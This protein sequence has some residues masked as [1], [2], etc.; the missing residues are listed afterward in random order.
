MS[1]EQ[2]AELLEQ[3]AEKLTPAAQYVFALAQRQV[4]IEGIENGV[5]ALGL[6][7]LLP[8]I[9]HVSG[10]VRA[11][12]DPEGWDARFEKAMAWSATA[13]GTGM[14]LFIASTFGKTALDFLLNPEWQTLLRLAKLVRP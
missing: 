3:L 6:L 8:L 9:W 1:P 5:I 2:I 7:L 13:F 11:T 14:V 12:I 10:K 4:V